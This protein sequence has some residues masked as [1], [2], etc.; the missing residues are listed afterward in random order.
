MSNLGNINDNP[1][2]SFYEKGPNFFRQNIS[3]LDLDYNEENKNL[4]D[5]VKIENIDT[6]N[7]SY[8][9]I[10][11][12]NN[13]L[14]NEIHLIDSKKTE[15][16]T[17]NF[18]SK[19]TQRENSES[20]YIK[21]DS[22]E[23]EKKYNE[24]KRIIEAKSKGRKKKGD[25]QKGKHN[26]YSKDNIIKKIKCYV[27]K[28]ILNLLNNSFRDKRPLYQ[29]N[30]LNKYI[31]E[32]INKDFN[33]QLLQRTLK[34]IYKYSN[35]DIRCKKKDERNSILIDKIYMENT[36]EELIKILEKTFKD[37][38]KDIRER[39]LDNFLNDI[40]E[41]EI[42]NNNEKDIDEYINEVK[43]MLFNYE[44]WFAFKRERKVKNKIVLI[45]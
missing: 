22:K 12:I 18:L 39:D 33:I 13:P 34:N 4:F 38:L 32:N 1:L 10:F 7:K 17:K 14:S 37:I 9:N 45:E 28:Y 42:R 23:E 35:L 36:E 11:K 25:N 44:N 26:K 21:N 20:N 3:F 2:D 27:F 5:I 15:L 40:K 24:T 31:N 41:K 6:K 30:S 16:E 8:E 19:K 43:I 29:F